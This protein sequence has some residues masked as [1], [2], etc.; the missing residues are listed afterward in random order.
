MTDDSTQM[1]ELLRIEELLKEEAALVKLL[2]NVKR[3]LSTFVLVD[4]IVTKD[5][6]EDD[7][8]RMSDSIGTAFYEGEGEMYI[9]IDGEKIEHFSNKFELDG[10]VFEE[11]VPNLFSF[12]NPFGACPN[13]R[14]L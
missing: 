6:D 11:P 13:L 3:Q 1:P 4:R 9:E 2:S 10:I 14:R 8:H 7:M 5:F 12:N